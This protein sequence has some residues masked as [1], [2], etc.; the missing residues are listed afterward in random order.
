MPK[1]YVLAIDAVTPRKP[2]I[3]DV[4]RTL[5]VRRPEKCEGCFIACRS[6][7]ACISYFSLEYPSLKTRGSGTGWSPQGVRLQDGFGAICSLTWP[8]N[9]SCTT[10]WIKVSRRR[11][12][13]PPLFPAFGQV[14]AAGTIGD[15]VLFQWCLMRPSNHTSGQTPPP[16]GNRAVSC[17]RA[18]RIN[19]LLHE[20]FSVIALSPYCLVE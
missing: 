20:I 11:N 16:S 3:A 9:P 19:S 7:C 5:V 10:G 8:I 13:R 14:P 17:R 6:D 4:S 2:N 1:Y 18:R 12:P 15:I